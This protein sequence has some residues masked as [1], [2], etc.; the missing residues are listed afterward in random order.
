V[1]Q[2]VSHQDE[3]LR[4]VPQ[5][6]WD[7]V[8]ARSEAV[9]ASSVRLRSALKRAGTYPRRLL[10]GL[11]A[12]A[13]CGAAFRCV[14]GRE[15]GC[16][17]Y[18][19]GGEAACSNSTRVRM[20][21]AE[22]KLL[23]RL[24]EEMLSPEGVALL[25]RRVREHAKARARLPKTAPKPLAAQIA[26]KTSEIEQLRALMK[27]GTLSQA[28]GQAAI[29]IAKAEEELHSFERLQPAK[30][31][32]ETARIIRMLPRAAEVLRKR[33]QGG[34]L[35]LRDPRSIVQGRNTLFGM[36][37]GKVPLRQAQVT[38][39]EKPYLIGRVGLN[40]EVLLQAAGSCV[41]FGSGGRI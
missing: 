27:S 15:Y 19:D 30:D 3:R 7:A 12:C 33:I 9:E 37:G 29:A 20:D 18:R 2:V 17:S 13:H 11:L 36:F 39:G 23:D 21:L 34:S 22:A 28:V 32:Q 8:K 16:A 6:L 25:E 41:E 1:A 35:G 26:K 4:I 38:L 40:R 31:E 5:P 14:N 24:A 10:S